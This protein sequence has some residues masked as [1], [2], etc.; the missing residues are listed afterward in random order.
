[1]RL[2]RDG[3]IVRCYCRNPAALGPRVAPGIEWC[4]GDLLRPAFPG[5][6]FYGLQPCEDDEWL[7]AGAQR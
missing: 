4:Q 5:A 2:E 1:M 3:S 7:R 6:A